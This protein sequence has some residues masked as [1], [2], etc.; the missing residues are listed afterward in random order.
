MVSTILPYDL[1][2]VSDYNF[3]VNNIKLVVANGDIHFKESCD[4]TGFEIRSRKAWTDLLLQV[5]KV[6]S[7]NDDF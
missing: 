1:L 7:I 6:I 5:V 2:D 3:Y 4:S